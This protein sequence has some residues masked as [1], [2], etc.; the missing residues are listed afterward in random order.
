MVWALVGEVELVAPFA[1]V[2][3]GPLAL[4]AGEVPRLRVWLLDEGWEPLRGR[5]RFW[6]LSSSGRSCGAVDVRFD[7]TP[8][9]CAAGNLPAIEPGPAELWMQPNVRGQLYLV[10]STPPV[11]RCEYWTG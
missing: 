5:G 7:A 2:E 1:P 10:G 8:T 4:V 6:C 11:L 9:D 3:V